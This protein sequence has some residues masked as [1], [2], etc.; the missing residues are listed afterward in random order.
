MGLLSR[1]HNSFF[2]FFFLVSPCEI[3][4]MVL[5][6]V[7]ERKVLH[8]PKDVHV[9]VFALSVMVYVRAV[10][11]GRPVTGSRALIPD[12]T[13]WITLIW[14]KF[15]AETEYGSFQL[16][17]ALIALVCLCFCLISWRQTH[18]KQTSF[19]LKWPSASSQQMAM[20]ICPTYFDLKHMVSVHCLL[21]LWYASITSNSILPFKFSVGKIF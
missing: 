21:K 4:Q 11:N 1:Q 10:L 12:V 15:Q 20:H 2:F 5:A 6:I 3:D 8:E 19:V 16:K 17:I 7:R 18:V 13:G 14:M 9:C